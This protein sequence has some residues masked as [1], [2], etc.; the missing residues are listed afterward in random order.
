MFFVFVACE[1]A[2]FQPFGRHH[3][4]EATW[5]QHDCNIFSAY[6]SQ[7]HAL[8]WSVNNSLITPHTTPQPHQVSSRCCARCECSL[9]PWVSSWAVFVTPGF[10][11][12]SVDSVT[13][14]E[15]LPL[16]GNNCFRGCE[17]DTW[18]GLL[19]CFGINRYITDLIFHFNPKVNTEICAC[20][21]L[22]FVF[23][24]ANEVG[25]ISGG[26]PHKHRIP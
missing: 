23:F 15:A 3:H 25:R 14:T 21:P 16:G 4:C 11:N 26:N 24:G 5:Q 22:Q 8:N 20:R 17:S 18:S 1:I 19:F 7:C 2:S 6:T 9:T 13:A 12:W 10:V